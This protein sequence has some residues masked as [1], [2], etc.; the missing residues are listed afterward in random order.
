M[1]TL[2]HISDLHFNSIDHAAADGLLRDLTDLHPSLVVVSGDL[3]Q[4]ARAGQYQAAAAFLH[5]LPTPYLVVP[6]NHDIPLFNLFSRFLTPLKNYRQY[7]T[8]DLAPMYCDEEI[9][10]LGINTARSLAWK[11]GRISLEQ[12]DDMRARLCSLPADLFRVVV[13]HHPFIP[14]PDGEGINLVGRSVKAL[15]VIDAC[16]VDLLLAGHLHHGYTNDVRSYYRERRG[17]VVVAQAGTAISTRLRREANSY[18]LI[19]L[20]PGSIVIHERHWNGLTFATEN[21]VHYTVINNEWYREVI[22]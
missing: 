4:R 2:A 5:R 18:N 16:N 20:E 3:T 11:S 7:I 14:P 1:R 21:V 15:D 10:V 12:I 9:A 19:T 22:R 13:T 8:T 17:S 6:G